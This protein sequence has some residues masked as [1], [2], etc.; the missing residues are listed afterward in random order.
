M[1]LFHF[2]TNYPV[3]LS[4]LGLL[5]SSATFAQPATAV[6]PAAVAGSPSAFEGYKP[7][8]DEPMGNWKA[9]NDNVAKIGGWREYAKQ[10]QQPDNTPGVAG[11]GVEAAPKVDVSPTTKAKP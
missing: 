8:T 3:A 7:Y 11:K 10:A 2:K 4:V 9:A 5:L 1:F 6:S